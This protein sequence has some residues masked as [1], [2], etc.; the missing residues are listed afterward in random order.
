MSADSYREKYLM[1]NGVYNTFYPEW[2]QNQ[3]SY[4]GGI[5]YRHSG[6]LRAYSIDAQTP[7]ETITTYDYVDGQQVGVYKGTRVSHGT[8]GTRKNMEGGSFYGEKIS[9]VPVYNY[10]KLIV[11]EYNSILFRNPVT[12]ILP[13]TAQI[14]AFSNNCDGHGNS[15]DEFM[16]QVDV[17]TTVSGVSYVM[18]T[19]SETADMP[20]FRLY[21]PDQVLDWEYQYDDQGDLKLCDVL[22]HKIVHE[23][24]DQFLKITEA[25]YVTIWSRSDDND[26]WTPDVEGVIEVEEG[27]WE[28]REPN[29]LGYIPL[30]PIYQNQ[31]LQNGVGITP[32]SDISQIQRS[33]YGDC[34]EIYSA[35]TYSAHP[36]LVVDA[37]THQL[38]QGEIGAE[39][40]SIV[41]VD[42]T[43]SGESNHTYEFVQPDLTAVTE[44]RELID[45]KIDKIT[46]TAM[47]RSDDL[48]RT[49]NSGVQVEMLDDKLNALIKKKASNMENAEQKIWQIFAD[50]TNT[51]NSEYVV[52]YPRNYNKKG[53]AEEIAEVS[54]LLDVVAKYQAMAGN[55][56]IDSDVMEALTTK[57][58][59]VIDQSYSQNGQ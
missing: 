45:N 36:S 12:R 1:P 57:L 3:K 27:I 5:T 6:Y 26:D 42:N 44:I 39:P 40:G 51:Q 2:S 4:Y 9:N 55:V 23:H 15:L 14:T 34:A 11:S 25:E 8:A 59:N 37:T 46:Q 50:Y 41:I 32:I 21:R 52:S 30:V 47:I 31:Q 58:T 43:L 16:S 7:S 56:A 24:Y 28:Y 29:M 49:A 13:E 19:Q 54:G 22:I 48:I 38:N 17:S 10:V 20:R 35:I 33:I 53:L 18:V